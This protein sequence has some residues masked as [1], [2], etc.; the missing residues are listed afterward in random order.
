M[1]IIVSQFIRV[2]TLLYFL[3]FTWKYF[4]LLI[5]GSTYISLN[6][7]F[8]GI[9]C[10]VCCLVVFKCWHFLHKISWRRS[11]V[12]NQWYLFKYICCKGIYSEKKGAKGYRLPMAIQEIKNSYEA[13]TK[14][15]NAVC[16]LLYAYQEYKVGSKTAYLLYKNIYI[17]KTLNKDFFLYFKH[18]KTCT[19]SYF[20][21]H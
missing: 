6:F 3:L 12:G 11:K 10:P 13:L 15:Y 21:I 1:F 17:N 8:Y 20:F 9:R 2:G 7:A 16:T 5:V 18:N 19:W 4:S 14:F